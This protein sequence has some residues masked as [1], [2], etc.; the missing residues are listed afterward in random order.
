MSTQDEYTNKHI[1]GS[2]QSGRIIERIAS[3][4]MDAGKYAVSWCGIGGW[5]YGRTFNLLKDAKSF[6]KT[7]KKVTVV[8]EY[9][10][11]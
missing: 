9:S 11:E 2:R 3:A 8:W 4:Y 5:C 7:L 10:N 6:Y 1:L